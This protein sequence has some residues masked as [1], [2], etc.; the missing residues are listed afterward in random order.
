MLPSPVAT[1]RAFATVPLPFAAIKGNGTALCLQKMLRQERTVLQRERRSG[2]QNQNARGLLLYSRILIDTPNE[3]KKENKFSEM[4]ESF[5][6]LMLLYIF[7]LTL[8]V[9]LKILLSSVDN[10]FKLF[11]DVILDNVFATVCILVYI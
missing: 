6:E 10:N 1:T 3:K 2:K 4:N 5:V 8:N 11:H 7:F 9:M